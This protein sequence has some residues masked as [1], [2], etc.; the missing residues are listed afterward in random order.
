MLASSMRLFSEPYDIGIRSNRYID[1]RSRVKCCKTKKTASVFL[2]TW[3]IKVIGHV[4]FNFDSIEYRQD[5]GLQVWTI[6]VR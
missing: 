2:V 6:R 1:Y 4:E 3:Y 5:H